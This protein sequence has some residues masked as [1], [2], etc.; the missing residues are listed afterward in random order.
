MISPLFNPPPSSLKLNNDEVHVWK[1]F[2]D[3][4]AAIIQTLA[5]TLSIEEKKRSEQFHFDRDRER[6]IVGRGILRAILGCYLSVEPNRLQFSYE[7]NG[8]PRLVE[9]ICSGT[10]HFNLSHSDDLALYGFTRD[11]EIGV[12]IERIRDIP[13]MEQIA[14]RFF[15]EREN[16]VFRA[17]PQGKKKKA[18]FNCWT[19]KEAFIKAT[20]DGLA[21]PLNTFDVTL[22][23]DDPVAL[24]N[25]AG[26]LKEAANWSLHALTPFLDYIGAIAVEKHCWSLTYW[27]WQQ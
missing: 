19:R 2:L 26:S 25:F 3:Q 22:A 16:A 4:P 12:D 13:E 8:K 20:G 18:F 9:Y 14:E 7:D 17:L 5:Q 23:P 1:A 24:T 15:S 6:F 21:L 27:K 10:I 11:R